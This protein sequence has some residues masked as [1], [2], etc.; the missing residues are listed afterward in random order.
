MA[1]V[2]A[3]LALATLV[4][5]VALCAG[6]LLAAAAQVRCIDAAREAARLTARGDADRAVPAARRV[7]PPNAEITVRLEGDLVTAVVS[8]RSPLLPLTL[9]AEAVA[10]REPGEVPA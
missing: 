4:A 8:A 9:R 6:A 2:E 7:A 10:A 3:A 5:V 1:T